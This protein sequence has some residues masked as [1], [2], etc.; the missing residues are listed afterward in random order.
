MSQPRTRTLPISQR[1]TLIREYRLLAS[2][3]TPEQ[4]ISWLNT[5][6]ENPGKSRIRRIILLLQQQKAL[7]SWGV[8]R[9]DA[10][11]QRLLQ[12]IRLVPGSPLELDGLLARYLVSPRVF[13]FPEGFRMFYATTDTK[14]KPRSE[15]ERDEIAAAM[16][17]LRLAVSDELDRVRKCDCE[18]YFLA[19]RLDQIYC[20]TKCRV[21]YNQSSEE[22][23]AKRRKYLREWY[24]LKKSGKVK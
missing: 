20:S 18:K 9:T 19:R 8:A 22:F 5:D 13:P 7:A 14:G 2:E 6:R 11:R 1:L 4:L 15:G 3:N 17:V 24:R 21:R 23:K 10:E 12:L 16:C